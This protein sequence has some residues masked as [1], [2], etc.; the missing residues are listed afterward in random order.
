MRTTLSSNYVG[1]S[2]TLTQPLSRRSNINSINSVV[3]TGATNTINH[4]VDKQNNENNLDNAINNDGNNNTNNSNTHDMISGH[5]Y[6]HHY[7]NGPSNIPSP[8]RSFSNRNES[9]DQHSS[10][11]D[12]ESLQHRIR[13]N[14]II[15]D[16]SNP[17]S[18]LNA[19]PTSLSFLTKSTGA[20]LRE[21]EHQFDQFAYT[22]MVVGVVA[23]FIG[24][25]T[26]SGAG[27][28]VV[29][30]VLMVC[31][32]SFW[33]TSRFVKEIMSYDRGTRDM[34]IIADY[35]KEG[36]TSYLNTQYRTIAYIA[37][38]TSVVLF[39]IYLFRKNISHQVSNSW[40]AI[41]TGISFLLG[42][43]CSAIAG[44]T[45]VWVSVRC[46][47]RVASAASRYDYINAFLI[48][49]RGGAVSAILSSAMC[50]LGI[51]SLYI[52]SH[53]IF[54]K[55]LHFAESE[56]PLLLGG[57]GFGASF[58]ALFMQ[59]GGG[60]YTKAADVGADMCGK[61]EQGIPEDD[62]R[63][64]AVIADL[65]GDNVGDC[66]GSM[67]DV[68]ESIA[69][70]IIG[71]MI[72]AGTLSEQASIENP[73]LYIF[74]PL[75]I[76]ALD[77]VVSTIGIYFTR[78]RS[79]N[80]D[81]I[82]S[83]KR[84]Y[85]ISLSVAVIFFTLICYE[86]LY[87]SKA[88]Q[89]WWHFAL[90][91]FLG[92]ICAYLL[93]LITQHYTDYTNEPV[94]RIAAASRTGHGTNIIAGVA[95]G[96]ESTA[97]PSITI[98]ITLFLAYLL[99]S[100]SGLPPHMSGLFGTACAT[101]GMLCTAVFVLSMNNFG[102]IA[103][104]AG[105]VVEMSEQS[106]EVRKITDRLDAVGNVTKAATK[107]YAVGGSALACFLL[108]QAFLDEI[109]V[110]QHVEF[111]NVNI[112]KV[113]VMIGGLLG[114]MMIFLFTGWS[115]SA[116][117]KTAEKVVIEVRNQFKDIPGIME[118]KAIPNYAKCVEIVTKEAL[119]EMIKPAILALGTPILVGLLF[120]MVGHYK[121]DPMLGVEVVASFLM[122]GSLTGLLM[123]IFL[124]NSGGA[125]DNAKKLIEA[126]GNK[127]TEIHKAAVT[128]DT[129]GDPF[130]D[131]AGPALHVVITT[132]STTALVFGP[133]FVAST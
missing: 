96:M 129:V 5:N 36:A 1:P 111:N 66:A 14:N 87:S 95:I 98:S 100:S 68:F 22:L 70:E 84:G 20:I 103:D 27:F 55:I 37:I 123:A 91:G 38:V 43:F 17:H 125:W 83:M 89:A 46:N 30:F 85:V 57:Y 35:I 11:I 6:T 121:H 24:F 120:R 32:V 10:F 21:A 93:V 34:Q 45:G 116:V 122:F 47:L 117:G 105:G 64:P 18:L 76:H 82:V 74:F 56:I 109:S 53:L 126:S 16:E 54:V 94:K 107:G 114:I 58:V 99:G 127:G 81:A 41:M 106:M 69:G 29:T 78:P 4:I 23:L 33:I 131:T 72:L 62:C 80:E 63:N 115:I 86:M 26:L 19:I 88:P 9:N 7:S 124:D 110:L 42:S 2:F 50:V 119:I 28:L 31:V 48:A 13:N 112:A 90:C 73:Q 71:T 113:E 128:G 108:Y 60:I 79:H 25:I 104:N 40:L 77:L 132:M 102:P 75:I 65:V 15:S 39:T 101:M 67:A 12:V 8:S 59:L 51:S 92:L 118:H 3:S 97:L 49:F 130:K 52:I 61:I 133:L 44:Y